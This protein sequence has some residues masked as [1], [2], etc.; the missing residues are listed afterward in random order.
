MELVH[1]LQAARKAKFRS[2]SEAVEALQ[3]AGLTINYHRYRRLEAGAWPKE[4]EAR[5]ISEVFNIRLGM[6]LAEDELVAEFIRLVPL[7][8]DSNRGLIRAA[9]RSWIEEL[10]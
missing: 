10:G 7:L 1:T 5:A 9:I 6:R 3:K 8:D 4:D 2:I